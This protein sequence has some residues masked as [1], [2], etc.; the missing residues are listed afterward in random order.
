[1]NGIS[2]PNGTIYMIHENRHH[3]Y[4]VYYFALREIIIAGPKM[5]TI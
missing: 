2:S 3:M 4:L 1:M 5:D